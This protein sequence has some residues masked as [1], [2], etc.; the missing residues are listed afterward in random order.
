MRVSN[1]SPEL[2]GSIAAIHKMTHSDV[3]FGTKS[4]K[5]AVH[6]LARHEEVALLDGIHVGR[7]T[8][9]HIHPAQLF[10]ELN[11]PVIAQHLLDVEQRHPDARQ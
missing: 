4:E 7:V 10:G 6:Q 5:V 3:I 1:S 8:G 9:D 11:L 2:T